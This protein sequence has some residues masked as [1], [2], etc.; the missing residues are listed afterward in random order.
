MT[1]ATFITKNGERFYLIPHPKTGEI[2]ELVGCT[3]ALKAVNKERLNDWRER[4]GTAEAQRILA[5]TSNIGS[6][7][8]GYIEHLINGVALSLEEWN[9]L[10]E[11][12][13]NA[14]RAYER[15]RKQNK[16]QPAQAELTV[17][18]FK[19]GYAATIDAEGYIGMKHIIVDWKTGGIFPTHRMQVAAGVM[20]CRET[21]P[22]WKIYEARI[23]HLDRLTGD[24][25]EVVLGGHDISRAFEGFLGAMNTWKFIRQFE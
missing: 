3:T 7:S 20:A 1:Q 14:I 10:D 15:W 11:R 12:E 13:R 21:Y 5:D 16:F 9:S 23:V 18:S 8:H 19:W 17:A 24:W 2:H 4:V 22:R 25:E 6:R